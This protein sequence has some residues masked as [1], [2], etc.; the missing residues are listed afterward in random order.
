MHKPQK[1]QHP[2]ITLLKELDE[3]NRINND[4]YYYSRSSDNKFTSPR[5]SIPRHK[6]TDYAYYP[7]EVNI[8]LDYTRYNKNFDY[9]RYSTSPP[10]KNTDYAYYPREVDI[11]L[12]YTRYNKNFDYSTPPPYKNTDYISPP[13]YA[14]KNFELPRGPAIPRPKNTNYTSPPYKN[15]EGPK[16]D[17]NLNSPRGPRRAKID[18]GDKK[19]LSSINRDKIKSPVRQIPPV[20]LHPISKGM[21]GC[22]NPGKKNEKPNKNFFNRCS[23]SGEMKP[24]YNGEYK[25]YPNKQDCITACYTE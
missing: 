8:G 14:N 9:P 17:K 12:D 10:Y 18:A 24:I 6:N 15:A 13:N 5:E 3:K 23:Q 7:R 2:L 4:R 1:E 11:G 19:P 16:P 20:V 21:W 25:E 22:Q